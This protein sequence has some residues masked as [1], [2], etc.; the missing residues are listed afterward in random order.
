[1]LSV[2]ETN[3]SDRWT[4]CPILRLVL[5][6]LTDKT[7]SDRNSSPL[8]CCPRNR[9]CSMIMIC[10]SNYTAI[11]IMNATESAIFF[12]PH[13][14]APDTVS[15]DH[16]YFPTVRRLK[17][18]KRLRIVRSHLNKSWPVPCNECNNDTTHVQSKGVTFRTCT[19]EVLSS[20]SGMGAI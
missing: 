2:L 5:T 11:S 19:G 12:P 15:R 1:M 14:T 7:P 16:G 9:T 8:Q 18:R 3:H 4:D 10:Y 13:A 20:N 17:I 6:L